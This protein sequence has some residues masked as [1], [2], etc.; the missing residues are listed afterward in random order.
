MSAFLWSAREFFALSANTTYFCIVGAGLH[1][2]TTANTTETNAQVPQRVAGTHSSL[3]LNIITNGVTATST[4]TFRKNTANGNQTISVGSGVTG[5]FTDSTHTDAVVA[6]DLC[7]VSEAMGATGTTLGIFSV[8]GLF[9]ATTNSA[10]RFVF[11]RMPAS[12]SLQNST[13]FLCITGFFAF[14][15]NNLDADTQ[16][17]M[18]TAGTWQN[19]CWKVTVNSKSTSSTG[20]MRLNGATTAVTMS[21]GAGLTGNFED[22]THSF[23]S[24][25]DDLI[26]QQLF[27]GNDAGSLTSV[28]T[29]IDFVTAGLAMQ[30][31]A[32]FANHSFNHNDTEFSSFHGEYGVNT[33]ENQWQNRP[34]VAGTVSFMSITLVNNGVTA[35]S[36]RT[37]RTNAV[38][39]NQTLSIGASTSGYFVDTTHTDVVAAADELDIAYANGATGADGGVV[40]AQQVV[41]TLPSS[42]S[43]VMPSMGLLGVGGMA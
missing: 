13:Q 24:A 30:Y 3:Y 7:C 5:E 17:H 10:T 23:T 22:T 27:Y 1:H 21:V 43:S 18:K 12:N 32:Q 35:S 14:D 2:I 9:A 42:A 38:N 41:F 19:Y 20:T 33:P 6:G 28:L 11:N 36:T 31:A 40:V 39:G 26:N 29:A 16:V 37:W 15:N 8:S 25:V 34:L 4:F